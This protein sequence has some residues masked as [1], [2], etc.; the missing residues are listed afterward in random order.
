MWQNLSD[1][2]LDEDDEEGDESQRGDGHV[3]DKFHI[4]S[5]FT[6]SHSAK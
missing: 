6:T 2:S 3:V 1:D 5:L 4:Y